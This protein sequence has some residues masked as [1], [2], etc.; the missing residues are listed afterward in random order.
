LKRPSI[1]SL[2]A[3]RKIG[4]YFENWWNFLGPHLPTSQTLR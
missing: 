1:K 4:A 2:L 3:C